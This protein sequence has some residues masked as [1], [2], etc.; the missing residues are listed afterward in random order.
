M[1]DFNEVDRFTMGMRFNYHDDQIQAVSPQSIEGSHWETNY[2][3]QE[4]RK[5]YC[6]C[7]FV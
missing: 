1:Q 6:V 5:S 7:R 2:V 3:F 4:F